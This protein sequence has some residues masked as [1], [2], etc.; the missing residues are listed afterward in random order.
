MSAAFFIS[1]AITILSLRPQ[2]KA[3]RRPG[4]ETY[5]HP[6][7]VRDEISLSCAGL[8]LGLLESTLREHLYS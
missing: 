5:T 8:G 2:D 7:A 4:G 3:F 6:C 1:P